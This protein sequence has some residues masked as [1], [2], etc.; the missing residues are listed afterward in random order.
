M[1]ALSAFITGKYTARGV[2]MGSKTKRTNP[3]GGQG[4]DNA[5]THAKY[6]PYYKAGF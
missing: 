5:R 1:Q 2:V 4:P 3:H 6:G